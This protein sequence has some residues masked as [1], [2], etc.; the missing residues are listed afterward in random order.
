M[1]SKGKYHLSHFDEKTCPVPGTQVIDEYHHNKAK[2]EDVAAMND[3][4]Q[5]TEANCESRT[6]IRKELAKV[7]TRVVFNTTIG[8]PI[9]RLTDIQAN[10]ARSIR[11]GVMVKGEDSPEAIAVRI[12]DA[13]KY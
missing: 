11:E 5:M 2:K 8:D 3:F 6:V 7:S 1:Y 13:C 10:K 4:I 12:L 9:Q